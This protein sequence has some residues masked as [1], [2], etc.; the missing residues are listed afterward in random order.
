MSAGTVIVVDAA[1]VE[2]SEPQYNPTHLAT[3]VQLAVASIDTLLTVQP[4]DMYTE[5]RAGNIASRIPWAEL[6]KMKQ[7][8]LYLVAGVVKEPPVQAGACAVSI[9]G[10]G[11]VLFAWIL[12]IEGRRLNIV[13][14]CRE[15]LLLHHRAGRV[16]H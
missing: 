13:V 5:L 8:N 10:R 14:K 9:L 3:S 11:L 2:A 4:E 1:L 16:Y 15:G 12:R 6:S 7:N